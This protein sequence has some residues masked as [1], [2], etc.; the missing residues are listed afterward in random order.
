M[1]AG[2]VAH[3][4]ELEFGLSASVTE[5]S[6]GVPKDTS[7]LGT[8]STRHGLSYLDPTTEGLTLQVESYMNRT[9]G[10]DPTGHTYTFAIPDLGISQVV[11]G[12]TFLTSMSCSVLLTGVKLYATAGGGWSITFSWEFFVEGSSHSS[13]GP[14]TLSSNWFCPAGTPILGIPPEVVAIA[15]INPEP[16]LGPPQTFSSLVNFTADVQV[17]ASGGW[18]FKYAGSGS[19]QSPPVS[20][21]PLPPSSGCGTLPPMPSYSATTTWN[22][23]TTSRHT[24]SYVGSSSQ[25]RHQMDRTAASLYLIPVLDR[26]MTRIGGEYAAL[27]YRAAVPYARSSQTTEC[28]DIDPGTGDW[29]DIGSGAATTTHEER[30]QHYSE[31][32]EEVGVDV[33][34]IEA[35]LHSA[36]YSPVVVDADSMDSVNKPGNVAGRYFKRGAYRG[37]Y[38]YSSEDPDTAGLVAYLQ[39][40]WNEP[41]PDLVSFCNQ[42]AAPHWLLFFYFPSQTGAG[43]Q[44]EV[45]GATEL[46]EDYWLPWR[47][48]WLSHPSLPDG[49]SRRRA[50]VLA[51]GLYHSA[52]SPFVQSRY[53]GNCESG[54]VGVRRFWRVPL[55][56]PASYTYTSGSS[57][58]WSGTDCTLSF[59]ATSVT[60]TATAAGTCTV[61][62]LLRSFTVE[63]YCFPQIAKG[64]VLDWVLGGGATGGSAHLVSVDGS[65]VLYSD[66]PSPAERLRPLGDDQKYVGSWRQD[67]GQGTVS[68]QG[69]DDL[70]SGDSDAAFYGADPAR[71]HHYMLLAGRGAKYLRFKFTANAAGDT[72]EVRYPVLYPP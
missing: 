37:A 56:P 63:P 33:A 72:M 29:D 69:T 51:E 12:G 61:D 27:W 67:F 30:S 35:P 17:T 59:G 48:Q 24:T 14:V 43:Y 1:P 15:K 66:T 60:A 53:F 22:A 45:D 32:L 57:S 47:G 34:T 16:L 13:G 11:T 44:W 23:Q 58:L 50:N 55:S 25:A 28:W 40:V 49:G 18:R 4:D 71:A 65:E 54:W 68:D 7:M 41:R 62:L 39:P 42:V 36:L 70:A 8:L 2:L 64:M 5:S 6:T 21:S 10:P 9:G 52:L 3:W 31:F 26:S 38:P 46:P 20:L 19:W